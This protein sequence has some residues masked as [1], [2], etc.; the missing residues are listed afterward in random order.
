[1][2]MSIVQS[3]RALNVEP[4]RL[5]A[6][7]VRSREHPPGESGLAELL[8]DRLAGGPAIVG[9]LV[10]GSP[11]HLGQRVLPADRAA[12]TGRRHVRSPDG[13]RRTRADDRLICGSRKCGR[14][15]LE[16]RDMHSTGRLQ[17]AN[18]NQ[19]IRPIGMPRAGPPIRDPAL[20]RRNRRAQAHDRG[21][22]APG[23]RRW[24]FFE[25]RTY[26]GPIPYPV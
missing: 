26:S 25:F 3:C 24:F 15:R 17:L 2:L 1:M 22:R 4:L 9:L 7:C 11:C 18:S 8:P 21:L 23:K 16:L 10:G 6:G 5:P 13:Y 14:R 20:A 19:N 12:K